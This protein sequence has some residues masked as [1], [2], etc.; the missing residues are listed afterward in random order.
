MF[1]SFSVKSRIKEY[2]VEF[3]GDF[4][5]GIRGKIK[6][7]FFLVI[8]KR[9]NE[10]YGGK[11]RDVFF[12]GNVVV[13]EANEESKTL[14]KC[15][16]LIKYFMERN[17]RRDSVVFAF[18]GGVVEDI[19]AF[20][21]MI[22]FRGIDWV[23]YP[24]TLLAQAD[25]CIGSKSSINV[26][27]Y[28]NLLGSF[29][30]P[31]SVVIDVNFLKTLPPA[32]IKSGIGEILHFYL[33]GGKEDLARKMMDEYEELI[34][35]PGMMEKYILPS[36]QIKKEVI[37]RDELDRGERNK[38]NYGHTFGHA[39]ESVSS[40][41]INHGQAVTIG[42][43][44]ANYI[45]MRAGVMET[46]IF[47]NIHTILKKNIPDFELSDSNTEAY[48]KALSKD[49]KNIGANLGCILARGL[50]DM[51]K[52]QLPMDDDFREYVKSYFRSYR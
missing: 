11:I 30:P 48:F 49:K 15:N 28:K 9:V 46:K 13:I 10:I 2:R 40:Y 39:I 38:F 24:T 37:E 4:A 6:D 33:I 27:G 41:A 47:D 14:S 29:Y 20:V 16:E 22:L 5:E 8:D 26:E 42:M 21:S 45:S 35:S 31:T 25:S 23:F 12:E 7:N 43:D 3:I 44:I 1:D 51:F 34:V 36:L 17:V 19:V 52:M 50:G 32:E 18:G